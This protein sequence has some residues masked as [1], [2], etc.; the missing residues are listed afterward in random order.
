MDKWVSSKYVTTTQGITTANL[1]YRQGA[2]TNQKVL[3]VYEKG[4]TLKL[5]NKTTYNNEIWYLCLD[6][7]DRF[8]WCSGK[9]IK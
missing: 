8:G 7:T 3:G 9:Y 2:G 4:V 5:L 1:N 6:N